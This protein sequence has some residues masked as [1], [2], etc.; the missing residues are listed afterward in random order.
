[1]FL[2]MIMIGK[3][4][5]KSLMENINSA[6]IV[7]LDSHF[8]LSSIDQFKSSALIITF[9]YE[10]HKL[11]E[12]NGIL[13]QISD[14]FLTSAELEEIQRQ[15]YRFSRWYDEPM[16]SDLLQ[17]E[18]INLG[19]LYYVEFHYELVPFLKKFAEITKIVRM[20]PESIFTASPQ[21][22]DMVKTLTNKITRLAVADKRNSK[23]LYDSIKYN[24][25]IGKYS[26]SLKIQK[27]TYQDIKNV[28]D[29]IIRNLFIRK[30]INSDKSI[31][32]VE[33]DTIKYKKLF[34]S[35]AESIISFCRR[36]PAIWNLQS[37]SIIRKSN[38]I[39]PKITIDKKLAS[40]EQTKYEIKLKIDTLLQNQSFFESFFQIFG[41]SFW[42][43][44]KQFFTNLC[45]KRIPEAIN[46]IF[47][48]KKLLQTYKIKSVLL[49]SENGLTEQIVLN[50]ANHMKIPT[51]LIQHGGV[52]FDS[53]EAY[54]YNIF[55]G[56]IPMKS[57]HFVVWGNPFA[58]HVKNRGISSSINI[59]GS[60]LYDEIFVRKSTMTLDDDFILLTPT[61]PAQTFAYDI[62]VETK[63]KYELIIKEI[64]KIILKFNKKLVVKL[65]PW[66]E[67]IDITNVVKEIIPDALIVKQGDI[68]TYIQ[69][70]E[71]LIAIDI[72]STILEAQILEKPIIS[73]SQKNWHLGVPSVIKSNS[74]ISTNISNFEQNLKKILE[75]KD[76]KRELIKNGNDYVK[77]SLV[78]P[79]N[80]S[81]KILN[82][83]SNL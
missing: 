76:Y 73:V 14:N 77:Y 71:V 66:Q 13:H 30:Q 47:I 3:N 79:G 59:L 17:Y 21:L 7:L 56:I 41:V 23:S 81:E 82:F 78:N 43:C 19:K 48:T 45:E 12:K 6:N 5:N 74:C 65:K 11:L 50:L 67:E 20:Y 22:S 72:S 69:N 37:L 40:I 53:D 25:Q 75:D 68:F 33:F 44:M 63:Q 83:L 9:D 2:L 15:S 28:I 70:C 62:T 4:G 58:E 46:E 36:R 49:W 16:V 64:C 38:C 18:G 8:D 57:N 32:L 1:M 51:V 60:P 61:S 52:G 34:Q 42:N 54:E 26:F 35:S 27:K 55:A 10:S 29:G 80:S 31:L 24:F 39:I